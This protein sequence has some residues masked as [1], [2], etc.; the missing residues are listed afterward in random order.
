MNLNESAALPATPT[1]PDNKN[2][3]D[4]INGFLNELYTLRRESIKKEGEKG[5]GNRVYKEFRALGYINNLK[6][7]RKALRDEQLS[8]ET[9]G[10]EIEDKNKND[11]KSDEESEEP[12]S[13][14]NLPRF[15]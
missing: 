2:K 5:I 9:L 10:E 14:T 6:T 11:L 1:Q 15:I 4:E 3:I 8:L 13:E 12:F 7:M